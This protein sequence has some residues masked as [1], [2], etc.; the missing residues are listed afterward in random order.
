[1][2]TLSFLGAARTVT[3][4]MFYL[5][6]SNTSILIDCGLFQGVGQEIKNYRELPFDLPSLNAIVLTHAHQDH[7]GLLPRLSSLGFRGKVIATPATYDLMRI[8]LMDAAHIHEEDYARM[9]KILHKDIKEPIFTIDDV[10]EME[11]QL[12]FTCLKYGEEYKIDNIKIVLRDA[13]HILGSAFVEIE[14]C[15]NGLRK[16]IVISGDIGNKNKPIVR[17]PES[18]KLKD[19]EIVVLESTYGDRLHKSISESKAEL[20][21]ALNETLPEGNVVI[22]VFS[23]ERAQDILYILRDF[24]ERGELDERVQIFLDSPLAI[25]ATS[26]YENHIEC[27]DDEARELVKQHK[28]PFIFNGVHLVRS[29]GASKMLNSIKKGAIILAGSGMCTGGRVRYHLLK[30]LPKPKSAVIFVGYQAE[31]TTGREIVDGTETIKIYDE[32]VNVNS[33]IYT[34]NGFSAHADQNILIG[35]LKRFKNSPGVYLVHGDAK[36][37][38]VFHNGLEANGIRTSMPE[39]GFSINI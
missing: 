34:I 16:G 38:D 17:D 26:I 12:T 22:P 4:S 7:C 21:V 2:V 25:N 24:K 37:M 6:T 15:E 32:E 19:A 13:G 27:F 35:W 3:G 31:G 18:P 23:L 10:L 14:V 1:M 33:K 9:L 8:M 28:N 20:K 11:K 39:E 36:R 30:N 29:V 5:K